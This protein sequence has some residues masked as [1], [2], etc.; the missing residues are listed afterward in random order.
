MK[1][2]RVFLSMFAFAFAIG[3]AFAFKPVDGINPSF[4]NAQNECQET[5]STCVGTKNACL[6]NVPE[7][8]VATAVQIYE[9]QDDADCAQTLKMGN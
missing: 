3:M 2:L 4:I 7:D 9:F 5:S 1:N 6:L 8:G